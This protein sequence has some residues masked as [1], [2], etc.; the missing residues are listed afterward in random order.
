[1]TLPGRVRWGGVFCLRKRSLGI[2]WRRLRAVSLLA[3]EGLE[4]GG[5]FGFEGGAAMGGGGARVP[6]VG[7]GGGAF[8]A[9]EVGVDG[10]GFAGFQ[11]IDLGVGCSPVSL[12]VVPEGEERGGDSGGRGVGGERGGEV[13]E[14]HGVVSCGSLGVGC[15]LWM[16]AGRCHHHNADGWAGG[17]WLRGFGILSYIDTGIVYRY[18]DE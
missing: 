13:G 3:Q 17:G 9:V 8:L 14:V 6:V 7:V 5:M 2:V 12:G 4:E 18:R 10:H 11:L 1:M 15:G 16:C